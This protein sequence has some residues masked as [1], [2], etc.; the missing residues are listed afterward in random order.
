[1]HGAK[2]TSEKNKAS[3]SDFE[4]DS[5]DLNLQSKVKSLRFLD[6]SRSALTVLALLMGITAL[7]LGADALHTYNT[8]SGAGDFIISLWPDQFNLQPTV[9]L[10][11]GSAIITLANIISLVFSNVTVVS[12]NPRRPWVNHSVHK[13]GLTKL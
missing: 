8:T 5:Q 11:V 3:M 9:S 12:S 13:L 7:G 1:M 10:V 6:S 4:V 2:M